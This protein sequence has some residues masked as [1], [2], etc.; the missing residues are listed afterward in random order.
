MAS[1]N[2]LYLN[3]RKIKESIKRCGFYSAQEVRLR[4]LGS[5]LIADVN[6]DNLEDNSVDLNLDSDTSPD[7]NK[8]YFVGTIKRQKNF[9]AGTLNWK[10]EREGYSYNERGNAEKYLGRFER[11]KRNGEG[12]YLWK[13]KKG[14]EFYH[15]LW[16]D[17]SKGDLGIYLWMEDDKDEML[18][19]N[20]EAFIGNMADDKFKNGTYLIKNKDDIFLYYGKFTP[21]GKRTDDNAYFYY[22]KED[23]LFKGKIDNGDL[24]EGYV[25]YFKNQTKLTDLI[26]VKLN[27]LSDVLELKTNE[28]LKGEEIEDLKEEM[29]IFRNCILTKD[30]FEIIYKDYKE[31]CKYISENFESQSGNEDQGEEGDNIVSKTKP[32]EDKESFRGLVQI[33]CQFNENNITEDI[34]TILSKYKKNTTLVVG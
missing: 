20:F 24:C 4:L 17:D 7:I 16:K 13:N 30:Y 14:A 32:F 9:F 10:F 21:D 25:A 15:G 2:D 12:F 8:E 31:C 22:S 23:K 29:N 19:S 34:R 6:K 11:D 5:N 27:K 18:K 33:C 26:Y 3:R 1:P 28:E